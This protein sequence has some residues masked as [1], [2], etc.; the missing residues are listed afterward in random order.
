MIYSKNMELRTF[1]LRKCFMQ[2]DSAP[3]KMN[4]GIERFLTGV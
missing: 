3:K 1:L 4:W 2:A